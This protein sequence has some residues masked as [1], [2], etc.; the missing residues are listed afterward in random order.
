MTVHYFSCSDLW[1]SCGRSEYSE[2]RAV[3]VLYCGSFN[4]LHEGHLAI[5]NK[6]T[7]ITG[8]RVLFEIS[9]VNCDKSEITIDEA[10]ER[11]KQIHSLSRQVV[12]TDTPYFINKYILGGKNPMSGKYSLI[13]GTDT[14][15]RLADKRYYF[16]SESE[17][18]RICSILNNETIIYVFPRYKDEVFII[19]EELKTCLHYQSNWNPI[20][21][22]SS[23]I[24]KANNEP[25]D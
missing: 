9:T 10:K 8:Q 6:V 17:K 22:S 24:R 13:M 1:E 7:E 2:G 4:P 20:E 25:K 16:N 21:I 15:S 19:P 5:A 3:R 12:I 23:Q 14:A 11:A 18:N